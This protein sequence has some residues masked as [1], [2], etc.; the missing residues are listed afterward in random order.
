MEQKHKVFFGNMVPAFRFNLLCLV[1][2]DE[3]QEDFRCTRAKRTDEVIGAKKV[4]NGFLAS[5]PKKEKPLRN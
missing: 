1:F 5:I 3:T 2:K 4:T